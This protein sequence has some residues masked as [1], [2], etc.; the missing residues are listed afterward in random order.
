MTINELDT[1]CLQHSLNLLEFS[2]A[3]CKI[4]LEKLRQIIDDTKDTHLLEC[5]YNEI[6]IIYSKLFELKRREKQCFC[7]LEELAIDQAL[8]EMD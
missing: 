8:E 4:F 1:I 2:I 7:A 6:S 5:C 3:E